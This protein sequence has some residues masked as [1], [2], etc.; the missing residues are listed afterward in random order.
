MSK[1]KGEQCAQSRPPRNAEEA[2]HLI[3]TAITDNR[4]NEKLIDDILAGP[5]GIEDDVEFAKEVIKKQYWTFN[6][7]NSDV[8][9]KNKSVVECAIRA[10]LAES[11][12]DCFD[13][14]IFAHAHQDLKCDRA[15]VIDLIRSFN[16]NVLCGADASL[17]RSKDI[18]L[19][20]LSN[21]GTRVFDRLGEA[22]RQDDEEAYE[23]DDEDEYEDEY[24]E[25]KMALREDLDIMKA[26]CMCCPEFLESFY[27]NGKRKQ[28]KADKE[29]SGCKVQQIVT[30][31]LCLEVL[32]KHSRSALRHIPQEVLDGQ[33]ADELKRTYEALL[34]NVDEEL[35]KFKERAL[36]TTTVVSINELLQDHIDKCYDPSDSCNDLVFIEAPLD[37]RKWST[38]DTLC[39]ICGCYS[40]KDVDETTCPVA[41]AINKY[42]RSKAWKELE[43]TNKEAS[44]DS[45]SS[46]LEPE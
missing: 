14:E 27:Y 38:K 7:F 31:S 8:V 17:L 32:Q 15:F 5:F 19:M 23:D 13:T 6:H 28:E 2:K 18:V 9:T 10:E 36:C 25:E 40:T 43:T 16:G 42:V 20:A 4:L 3:L 44:S 39:E 45:W 33:D 41:I 24:D 11:P 29:D 30:P 37:V 35:Q 26:T 22:N 1:E 21:N 12:D 46:S 34:P